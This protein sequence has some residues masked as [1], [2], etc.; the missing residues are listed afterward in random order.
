[1]ARK[2]AHCASGRTEE[3]QLKIEK[4]SKKKNKYPNSAGSQYTELELTV[5]TPYSYSS[6]KDVTAAKLKTSKR[7]AAPPRSIFLRMVMVASVSFF[8]VKATM[9]L[10]SKFIFD[11]AR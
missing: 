6:P 5:S 8:G 11:R 2:H 7:L 3:W 1:V 10:M 9:M 4:V